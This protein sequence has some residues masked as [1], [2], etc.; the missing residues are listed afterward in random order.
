[1]DVPKFLPI[2]PEEHGA[3]LVH[4]EKKK[5]NWDSPCQMWEL[6][7]FFVRS[8]MALEDL[9]IIWPLFFAAGQQTT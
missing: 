4:A 5:K 3:H 1:M 9:A 8:L 6:L 2:F 7:S